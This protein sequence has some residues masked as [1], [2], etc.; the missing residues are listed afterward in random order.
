MQNGKNFFHLEFAYIL[1]VIVVCYGFSLKL[2]KLNKAT[3]K[4][5]NYFTTLRRILSL[6][7][8]NGWNFVFLISMLIY[9]IFNLMRSYFCNVNLNLKSAI[10]DPNV[11]R[12]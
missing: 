1:N 9:S 7:D 6:K 12:N 4:S 5:G 10:T 2:P 11:I 3:S 8:F